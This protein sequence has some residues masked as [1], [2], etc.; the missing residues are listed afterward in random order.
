MLILFSKKLA[1]KFVLVVFLAGL[2]FSATAAA[3][4]PVSSICIEAAT[5]LVISEENADERRPPASM[6]KMMLLLL[7]SEGIEAGKW[8]L[9]TPIVIS[10]KAAA[11]GG[12]GV[13]LKKGE[14]FPLGKIIQAVAVCSANDAAMAVAEGLWGSEEAYLRAAN[15]RA[16]ELTMKNTVFHSPHGLP[17]EDNKSFDMTT[18]RDMARLAQFCVLDETV[19]GWTSTKTLQLRKKDPVRR[20]TNRLLRTMEECDGLKTGFIND[21]GFCLTATAVRDGVRLISVVMGT[22]SNS[23]RFIVSQKLLED[24]FGKITKK[25]VLAKGAAVGDPVPV[26]NSVTPTVSLTAAD[27]LWVVVKQ[28]DADK[29]QLEPRFPALIQAPVQAGAAVGEVDVQLAGKFLGSV[30][31]TAPV[32]LKEAD[33]AWKLRNSLAMPVR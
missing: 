7:A 8:T 19:L 32:S 14:E 3:R 20:N 30:A 28:D 31:L 12:A 25:C 26:A 10:E 33:L 9:E 1:V 2:L 11:V 24:S 6:V 15:K 17:P 29:L 4:A 18:A 13:L 23:R 27:D 21:A 16:R 5:G 22:S